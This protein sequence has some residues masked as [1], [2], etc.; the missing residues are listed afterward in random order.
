MEKK[1][2]SVFGTHSLWILISYNFTEF[3]GQIISKS[4]FSL[5]LFYY[6]T[7]LLLAG[8]FI[9]AAQVIFSIWNAVNDPIAG[10]VCARPTKWAKRWGRYYPW[11]IISG[12]PMFLFFFLIFAPPTG[13]GNWG[14]FFWMVLILCL[15][16]TFSSVFFI[17]TG[18]MFPEKFRSKTDRRKSGQINTIVGSIGMVVA[19]VLPTMLYKYG[20]PETYT[21]MAGVMAGLGLL[22][23]ILIFF[24]TK[25]DDHMVNVGRIEKPQESFFKILKDSFKHRNFVLYISVIFLYGI[26]NSFALTS[27]PYFIKNVME[28]KAGVLMYIW[29]G[30]ILGIFL[31]LPLWNKFYKKYDVANTL[32]VGFLIMGISV[33]PLLFLSSLIGTIIVFFFVG[34]GLGGFW[35]A[36]QPFFGDVMDEMYLKSGVRNTGVYMGIQTFFSRF[37]I[38]LQTVIFI[39]IHNLTGYLANE[40]S[41]SPKAIFGIRIH[42]ML[43]PIVVVLIGC[44]ILWK[45]YD[46]KGDKKKAMIGKL[47]ERAT[48]EEKEKGVN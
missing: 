39:G 44:F 26:F 7:E 23:V 5:Y 36:Y 9:I 20:Q 10:Y 13:M 4:F 28:E 27:M 3:V 19:S 8:G 41:Q 17:N 6:E 18:S 30:M 35:I 46:L 29:G 1:V 16:D 43:I 33:I 32:M 21:V 47:A 31:F 45:L 34:S 12:I 15:A 11:I 14:L 25:P 2:N 22:F 24:G 38:I 40:V 42:G 48:E 37:I